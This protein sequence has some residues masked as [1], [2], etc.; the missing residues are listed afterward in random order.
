MCC[1]NKRTAKKPH[2]CA[3]FLCKKQNSTKKKPPVTAC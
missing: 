3:A 2:L 1:Y